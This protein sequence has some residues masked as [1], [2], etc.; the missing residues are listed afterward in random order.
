MMNYTYRQPSNPLEEFK[1]F[2]KQGSSLS[3]LVLIN[4][5]IWIFIQVLRVI[6][7]IYNNPD[8]N[9]SNTLVLHALAIPAFVP[10]L[11]AKPWTLL[12]YMFLHIDIWHLLF[13]MIW[14]YWFG[15]IFL[16]FLSSRQLIFV[17][18]S[19]GLAGAL[20]YVFAFNTFPVFEE[21][22]PLSFALGASASVMAIVTSISFY[23]PNYTIQL[24]LFGKIR[25]VYLAI[26]L[27]VFDFFMIPSGNAGGHLAHIGGALFGFIFSQVIRFSKDSYNTGYSSAF[28]SSM[29]DRFHKKQQAY[30]GGQDYSRPV[31]DE[32]YNLKKRENQ[33]KVDDILEKISKGGYDSLTKQ[34][35]EFLFNTSNKR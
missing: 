32:E 16:E 25:I 27:F 7:F 23:V 31:S 4:V 1:K 30:Q 13:N 6:F 29:K 2:F 26:I 3:V 17:Y 33:E 34:E 14:L 21:I 35:K 8:S 11:L 24:F 12:T 5:A 20:V 22:V 9:A 28:F 19:G 18:L 15:K 10:A